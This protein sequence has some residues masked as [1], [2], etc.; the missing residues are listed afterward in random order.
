MSLHGTFWQ[1][2]RQ[3]DSEAFERFLTR[4]FVD[5]LQR[6]SNSDRGRHMVRDLIIKVLLAS[7]RR[8]VGKTENEAWERFRRRINSAE[9][10]E[11]APE[12]PIRI[13]AEAGCV[14]IYLSLDNAP[15]LVVEN[16]ITADVPEGQL[17][18]YGGWL[19]NNGVS[20]AALVL[21]THSTAPPV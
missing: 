16:K 19:A 2:W 13:Q 12:V 9:S 4:A 20:D 1:H 7:P 14:D 6:L 5:L 10:F 21:L 18:K 17:E 8:T 11:W 3:K 15:V